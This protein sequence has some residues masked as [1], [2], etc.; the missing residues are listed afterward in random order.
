MYMCIY[1]SAKC[2]DTIVKWLLAHRNAGIYIYVRMC[3][4]IIICMYM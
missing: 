3:M 1:I 4:D 2:L